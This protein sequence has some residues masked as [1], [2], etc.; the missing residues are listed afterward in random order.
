VI[1]KT[2][3]SA[4][5]RVVFD[6]DAAADPRLRRNHDAFADVAVVTDVNH[7]VELRTASDAR[8]TQCG[9]IDASVRA[10]LNI[11]FDHDRADLRKFLVAVIVAN[12][13]KAIGSEANARVQNYAIADRDAVIQNNIRMQ[14]A[15]VADANVCA[16]DDTRFHARVSADMRVFT[17]LN[18]RADVCRQRDVSAFSNNSA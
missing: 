5:H 8:A 3:L 11:L 7:V 16:N 14:H 9:A 12:I 13:S 4:D 10:E 1:P 2:N 6:H 15:F 17:D 18:V